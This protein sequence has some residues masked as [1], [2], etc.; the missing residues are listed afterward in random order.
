[1][2]RHRGSFLS[3]LFFNTGNYNLPSAGDNLG[4]THQFSD[5]LNDEMLREERLEREHRRA[6]EHKEDEPGDKPAE[7]PNASAGIK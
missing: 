5:A 2:R 7:D 4:F 6:G 1:M 3:G